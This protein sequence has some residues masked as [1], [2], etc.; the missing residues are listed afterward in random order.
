[1]VLIYWVL[2]ELYDVCTSA[3]LARRHRYCVLVKK[4]LHELVFTSFWHTFNEFPFF[5]IYCSVQIG[6]F[7][8]SEAPP[9]E[10]KHSF[11]EKRGFQGLKF[12]L[13]NWN[14]HFLYQNCSKCSIP[15]LLYPCVW[16]SFQ[17]FLNSLWKCG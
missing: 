10:D 11:S 17:Y 5:P 9:L 7:Q 3:L 6:L 13:K 4:F 12:V 14:Y 2:F 15:C 1:M 16:R 8:I